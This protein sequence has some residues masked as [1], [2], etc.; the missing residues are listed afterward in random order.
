MIVLGEEKRES[1]NQNTLAD[2]DNPN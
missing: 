1:K 2:C